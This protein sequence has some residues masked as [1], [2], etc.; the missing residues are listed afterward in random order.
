MAFVRRAHDARSKGAFRRVSEEWRRSHSAASQEQFVS[1]ASSRQVRENV[2]HVCNTSRVFVSRS[3]RKKEMPRKPSWKRKQ[4]KRKGSSRAKRSGRARDA[5]SSA[6]RRPVAPR[7][8]R[9]TFSN[10]LDAT[11]TREMYDVFGH[12]A[13]PIH[14]HSTVALA[15]SSSR[16]PDFVKCHLH[17]VNTF[18]RSTLPHDEPNYGLL[19]TFLPKVDQVSLV[20]YHEHIRETGAIK[21][22][23]TCAFIYDG[24][25]E[26]WKFGSE[27]LSFIQD[28]SGS[29]VLLHT[30][31]AA[32]VLSDETKVVHYDY[33]TSRPQPVPHKALATDATLEIMEDDLGVQNVLERVLSTLNPSQKLATVVVLAGNSL[34]PFGAIGLEYFVTQ[35]IV[36]VGDLQNAPAR[37][38]TYT[39]QE[40]DVVKNWLLSE[41]KKDGTFPPDSMKKLFEMY[42]AN[43]HDTEVI[44]RGGVNY[45]DLSQSSENVIRRL[46][47]ADQT[48]R[49]WF[50]LE[51]LYADAYFLRNTV[52]RTKTQAFPDAYAA[53]RPMNTN[54]IFVAGPNV[55]TTGSNDPKSTTKRSYNSALARD[56]RR[57]K[58]GV[59]WAYFAALHASAMEGKRIVFLP[60]ISGGIYAG[61][62]RNS[63]GDKSDNHDEVR[64]LIDEVL[65]MKCPCVDTSGVKYEKLRSL[66]DRVILATLPR[67][68]GPRSQG[69]PKRDWLAM[70]SRVRR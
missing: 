18:A 45:Q 57:F 35:K 12:I 48:D 32:K 49:N 64:N 15:I 68:R 52:L 67:K 69:G 53:D 30:S 3:R 29:S 26:F 6:L 8:Y 50:P 40:E 37:G 24:F 31:R 44:S 55:G 39:T 65:D 27:H 19:S 43:H 5:R 70:P 54:F 23:A 2:F 1:N 56:E 62:F 34:L 7:R 61:H 38:G 11:Q 47:D 51:R 17:S 59:F 22:P 10:V 14:R 33:K 46:R 13:T 41:H 66:F 21:V 4:N 16:L 63:F 42:G 60:W 36:N 28:V 20:E 9:S 25:Q 58:E